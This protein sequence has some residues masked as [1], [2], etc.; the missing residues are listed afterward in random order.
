[1][2]LEQ[3][4]E[5]WLLHLLMFYI[6]CKFNTEL[7]LVTWNNFY[8][9]QR[10]CLHVSI[11][12]VLL[13]WADVS[14][15]CIEVADWGQMDWNHVFPDCFWCSPSVDWSVTVTS[16]KK[17]LLFTE[18]FPMYANAV[19]S[20]SAPQYKPQCGSWQRRSCS[21]S[22]FYCLLSALT[23]CW[24]MVGE[25]FNTGLVFVVFPPPSSLTELAMQERLC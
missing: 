18:A 4:N 8:K 13:S 22:T 9:I 14:E 1:M 12:M 17:R 16:P 20:S 23:F 21:S 25:N 15:C 19:V 6:P 11:W 2:R 24:H 3:A 7:H 5:L 10:I